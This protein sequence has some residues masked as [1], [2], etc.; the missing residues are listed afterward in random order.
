MSRAPK[1]PVTPKPAPPVLERMGT[2]TLGPVFTLPLDQIALAPEVYRHRAQADLE[3]KKAALKELAD[4]LIV[5]GQRDPLV[6]YKDENPINPARPYVLVA[7]HR[8][9]AAMLLLCDKNTPGFSPSMSV[10]A[11]EI[12]GGSKADYLLLSV[13]DNL[14]HEPL[15]SHHLILAAVSLLG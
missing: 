15:D 1:Q 12:V 6:V 4:N 9:H 8:R 14:F 5:E 3:P 10:T 13:S 11:R 2:A 7:G